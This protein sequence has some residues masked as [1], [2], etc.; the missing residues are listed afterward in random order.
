MY[1]RDSVMTTLGAPSW[2]IYSVPCAGGSLRESTTNHRPPREKTSPITNVRKCEQGKK[3]FRNIDGGI[4]CWVE[5][6]DHYNSGFM[7]MEK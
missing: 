7:R 1:L 3:L 2:V 6:R 5:G 4:N